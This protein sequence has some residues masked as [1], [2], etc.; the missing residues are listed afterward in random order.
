M[1]TRNSVET[2]ADTLAK[3]L[4][5]AM[6]AGEVVRRRAGM[7]PYTGALSQRIDY[8]QYDIPEVQHKLALVVRAV[9][10]VRI[11]RLP[12]LFEWHGIEPDDWQGLALALACAHVPGFQE[13]GVHGPKQR[14][15]PRK[16]R[17]ALY[18]KPTGKPGRPR[19]LSPEVR[20]ELVL[21]ADLWLRSRR[22]SGKRATDPPTSE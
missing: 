13:R 6:R 21:G 14:G 15:R 2:G 5:E 8:R 4:A 3:R 22:A 10:A 12:L 17:N 18:I 19:S 1:G 7:S 11:A 9:E 16:I 20:R